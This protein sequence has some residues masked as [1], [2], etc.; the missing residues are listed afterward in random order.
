MKTPDQAVSAALAGDAAELASWSVD[1]KH[2]CVTTDAAMARLFDMS[3]ESAAQG[4]VSAYYAK[5]HPD[6]V[7]GHAAD[8]RRA[9]ASGEPY[10]STLRVR[11]ADGRY[12]QV[13][14][15]GEVLYDSS[16]EPERLRGVV[17]DITRE[18]STKAELRDSEERYRTLFEA[19]DEGVCIIEMLYDPSG[20]P[21]DYR[22]LEMNS[23]FVQHTGLTDAV[24]KTVLDMV[25]RHDRHW[26]ETYGRVASTGEPVR[27][28]NEAKAMNRWFDVYATRVG[29]ADSRKVALLFADITGRKRAEAEAQRVA[30]D[31]TAADRRKTDFL[32][33]LA[34]E[35]RNPLAPLR[36]GLQVLRLSRGN[37]D[38][39][40]RVV[41]VMERQ[42]GHMVELVDDLL[43][44]ARI[45]RGQVA[46]KQAQVDLK[47]VLDAAIETS[48]PMID[49]HHHRLKVEVAGEALPLFAD[50]TRVMQVVNNL[51]NNAAKYT[52]RGGTIALVARRDGADAMISVADNGIGIAAESLQEVFGLFNQVGADCNRAHG[53]LG[54]G[55]SLL[56]S[57]VELHGGSVVADSAGAG[58]GSVFTVRLPLDAAAAAEA[59]LAVAAPAAQMHS[60]RVLVVDD[61]RDAADTLSALLELLGHSAQ[62]AN[63]GRA[64]LG[65]VLDFCPQVVFLDIGMPGINGYDVARAI[66]NDRRLDQPLLVALTGWGG[67]ADRRRTSDADFDLHL[68]KPVDL[69][70]IEKMLRSV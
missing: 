54:I 2:D 70:A 43:D 55:L 11:G 52:P 39:T 23:A 20:K 45:T 5:L 53:G 33:T 57:L 51:L 64:A 19:I 44:I 9:I 4:P 40:A 25:P 66:R 29:A 41:D 7:I 58:H 48:L 62:V 50:A 47:S 13:L 3:P 18:L 16:G 49:E 63:D 65:A 17:L 8:I 42:L 60:V 12:R 35:L 1:L 36:S 21:C 15:R 30:A 56:R 31:L 26:F 59:V 61:N 46:L 67:E 22:F 14:A 38:A 27:F 68:T 24:G 69:D 6:D 37:P 34:H 10:A 28:V 32:A